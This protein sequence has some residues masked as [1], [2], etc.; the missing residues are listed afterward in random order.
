M[1]NLKQQ[2]CCLLA[3]AA[4]LL[5][6]AAPHAAAA[7]VIVDNSPPNHLGGNNMGYAFQAE[8]FSV[9][10][11]AI[12]TGVRFWSLEADSAYRGSISWSIVTGSAGHPGTNTLA[13]GNQHTVSRASLGTVLGLTEYVNE[14]ALNA[15]LVL[16]SGTYWLTLHNGPSG[17]LGDPN[18][19]LWESAANNAS[20]RGVERFDQHSAWTTNGTE[21]AFQIMAVPEPAQVLMLLVGMMLAASMGRREQRSERFV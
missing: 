6:G 2:F 13:S 3:C 8:D 14:F 4:C 20:L 9:A 17:N 21:H 16:G 5:V 1:R 12:L 11:G 7:V 15:P 19:F 18:E 10:P